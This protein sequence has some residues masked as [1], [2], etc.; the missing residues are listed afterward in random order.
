MIKILFSLAYTI[1]IALLANGQNKSSGIYLTESD[2]EN[3]KLSYSA[4]DSTAKNA[5]HFH[6][7]LQK[8]FITIKYNGEKIILFK[9]DIFA[10]Q[11]KGKIYLSRDFV[12]YDFI[13]KGV[14]WIYSKEQTVQLGKGVKREKKYYYSI[15]G[16]DKIIPLTIH[17]LKKSFPGKDV[18]HN[19]LDAQFRN[20]ADLVSYNEIEK[21]Y[22]VNHL[23]E[24]TIFGAPDPLP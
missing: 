3:R 15:S 5:I 7:F 8:P 16:K 14:I 12:S 11:K 6:E 21:K 19:F 2:F 23:L 13:E 1:L 17:N 9:D 24:T 20:D 22:R 4:T 10:Y 18:F